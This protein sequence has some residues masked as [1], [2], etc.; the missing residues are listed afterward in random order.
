MMN[1]R[2]QLIFHNIISVFALLVVIFPLLLISQYNY[3]TADDWSYGVEGYRVVQSGGKFFGVL[4]AA[5][6]TAKESYLSWEGRFSNAF[7][8]AL[9]PGIWGEKGYCVVAYLMIGM[10]IFSEIMLYKFL[11]NFGASKKNNWYV[12][13][14][15]VPPLIMQILY[16]PSPEE[17]FYW[18]TGAVNYTFM[19]GLSLLLLIVFIKL[20]IHE[21]SKGK[22]ASMAVL[23]AL[24]AI[25][26]GGNNYATSLSCF[27]A[28]CALSGFFL[29]VRRKA[30]Y[31]TWFIT[32]LM[33]TSLVMCILA[34]GN[35]NRINANFGGETGSVLE[36][37]GM[38]IVRSAVNIYSWTNIKVLLM[39][40]FVIPF[41]WMAVKNMEFRFSVP[42]LFTVITFGLYSSQIVATMYVDGTTG[43]GRMAAILYYSYLLWIVGN[44]FYWLGWLRRRNFRWL[45]RL[46]E[47]GERFSSLLLPYCVLIGFVLVILIYKTDLRNLTSYKA[48]R[49]WRQ[50]F[51]QQYA[52]EWDARLE[53]LHDENVA[54]VE[55]APLTVRPEMLLYTDLQEESGYYWVNVA[56]AQYYG[57]E[58]VHI[59]LPDEDKE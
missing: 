51:A 9:Q 19:Y 57:K 35:A 40:I 8:A 59:V 41:M 1:R 32:L 24:M 46:Q 39:L 45:Q 6:R 21:Y 42:P 20:A 48:Y 26:V 44:V 29:A 15:V 25:L 11:I 18:Y 55:F 14:V 3:P 58:Y 36:A 50:G 28:L 38:S 16:T 54:Q 7:L 27:L 33:G 37:I 34:P 23:T 13:P 56:C 43:G 47:V 22:Y 53:V 17:S 30:F 2:G 10:L 4:I 52:A 5:V 12:L 31:R 49:N